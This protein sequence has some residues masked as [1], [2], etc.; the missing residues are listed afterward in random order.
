MYL[1]TNA[2]PPPQP[3]YFYDEIRR[4]SMKGEDGDQMQKNEAAPNNADGGDVQLRKDFRETFYW[5]D[6]KTRR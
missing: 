5:F 2:P 6:V 1:I 4:P 3:E